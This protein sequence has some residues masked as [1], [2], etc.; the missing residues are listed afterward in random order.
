MIRCLKYQTIMKKPTNNN[1]TK[2]LLIASSGGHLM[3]M[4]QLK[5]YWSKYDYYFVAYD[6]ID[7]RTI[8]EN[9]KSRNKAWFSKFTHI[10]NPIHVIKTAFFAFKILKKVR[11]DV[12]FSTGEGIAV[13]FYYLGKVLFG[14]KT[15]FLDS[16]SK[17]KP[18]LS[19]KLLYPVCDHLL[20]Q[21]PETAEENRKISY[22]G[23]VL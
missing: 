2:L 15:I 21:W 11:P 18:S 14:C 3:E 8:L 16:V 6:K 19:A 20:A 23:S 5:N 22:K 10:R 1:E 4:M 7:S 13:P 12:M 17:L 9:E